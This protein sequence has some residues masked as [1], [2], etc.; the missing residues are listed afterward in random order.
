MALPRG[1][2]ARTL[3]LALLFPAAMDI[4]AQEARLLSASLVDWDQLMLQRRESPWQ[5]SPF[6]E[7]EGM[8][9]LRLRASGLALPTLEKKGE[10]PATMDYRQAGT[11]LYYSPLKGL[12]LGVGDHA[13]AWRQAYGN[14]RDWRIDWSEER[15]S[16]PVSVFYRWRAREEDAFYLEGMA[17][18]VDPGRDAYR[19]ALGVGHREGGPWR[20]EASYSQESYGEG[21]HVSGVGPDSIPRDWHALYLGRL[22]NVGVVADKTWDWGSLAIK[23]GYR[24]SQPRRDGSAYQ[25]SDSS[26]AILLGARWQG[27]PTRPWRAEWEYGESQSHSFGRRLPSG[28]EGYKRFHYALGHGYSHH[29]GWEMGSGK[30]SPEPWGWTLG[31]T[32]RFYRYRNVPLAEAWQDRKETL[33]YNRLESSFLADVYG[34]FHNSS[35]MATMQVDLQHLALRPTLTLGK[36]AGIFLEAGLPLAWIYL[37]AGFRDSTV[38][39]DL[40]A[41][42]TERAYA[43]ESRG[44]MLLAT[45]SLGFGLRRG[46]LSASARA[47]HAFVAWNGL[48]SPGDPSGRKGE[49]SSFPFLGNGALLEAQAG[50][51]F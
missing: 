46:P 25:L 13:S 10:D 38:T 50:L 28:S 18:A 2:P 35:E 5:A 36:D 27:P 47:A 6:S 51:D 22:W 41:S 4:A 45:P 49:A 33:S 15:R 48:R 34:G 12:A 31:L 3:V 8:D 37:K 44:P 26:Q 14:S 32:H 1:F 29:A 23:A 30:D 7:I 42:R 39:R 21:F 17:E 40:V 9:R 20:V 11:Q 19:G 24:R 43:W 16:L